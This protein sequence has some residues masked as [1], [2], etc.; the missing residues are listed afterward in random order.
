MVRPL[1]G[2]RAQGAAAQACGRRCKASGLHPQPREARLTDRE[3]II[4]V[5]QG[6]AAL[7]A[8]WMIYIIVL[9]QAGWAGL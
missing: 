1:A 6:V 5:A 2:A 8:M 4:R 7:V 3:F 9:S